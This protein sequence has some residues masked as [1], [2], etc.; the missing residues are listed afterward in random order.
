[1]DLGS[2]GSY[3]SK[4]INIFTPPQMSSTCRTK[5]NYAKNVTI[6]YGGG[7]RFLVG[8]C[9]F[10]SKSISVCLAVYT[11]VRI[12]IYIYIY[13]H[14]PVVPQAI[15]ASKSLHGFSATSPFY[16]GLLLENVRPCSSNILHV[17]R[18]RKFTWVLYVKAVW[19]GQFS[20]LLSR[21]VYSD[22]VCLSVCVC[23]V[24]LQTALKYTKVMWMFV[25]LH[26]C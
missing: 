16:S 3:P 5:K 11:Y 15:V 24:C 14:H 2:K 19:R 13:T 9:M 6:F 26:K 4:P 20:G 8:R 23:L 22:F 25:F 18:V 12:C 17:W 21:M 7:V 10:P 1:M